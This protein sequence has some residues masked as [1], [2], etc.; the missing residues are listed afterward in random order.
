MNLRRATLLAVASLFVA[1]VWLPP[2]TDGDAGEYLLMSESLFAHASPELRSQDVRRLSDL[3]VRFGASLNFADAER[4]YFGAPGGGRYSYHFWGYSLLALPAK[5][6]LK[7]LRANELKAHAITNAALL[8]AALLAIALLRP[9]GRPGTLILFTLLSPVLGFLCWPHT[10]VLVLSTVTLALAFEATD[11]RVPA[12]LAAA[13]GAMQSPPLVL[14]VL[15]LALQGISSTPRSWWR[16]ALATIP[17]VISPFF[18]WALFRTPSVI[19]RESASLQLASAKKIAELFVDLNIGMLPYLPLTLPLYALALASALVRR[20]KQALY[21]LVA[22]LM[23]AACTTTGNW[24]HGTSGPSR[25]TLLL[26]PFVFFGVASLSG[27]G[28]RRVAVPMAVLLQAGIALARGGPAARPDYLEH[29]YAARF[30][31]RQAPGLYSPSPEIF[32]ARTAHAVLW[33]TPVVYSWGGRCLKGLAAPGD[34]PAL[35]EAC[36]PL[37]PRFEPALPQRSLRYV[38]YGRDPGGGDGPVGDTSASRGSS[39]HP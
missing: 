21:G 38:D 13:L 9:L 24:N 29:S 4:G 17:A 12:V 27:T 23:A 19:G 3:A 6:V 7:A 37:R 26:M 15:V 1:A 32:G 39:P 35:A 31:L 36:A 10:E 33:H 20:G 28:L 2:I 11:R 18:F 14:L 16:L 30:V 8:G 25:Y 34:E 22:L 5:L